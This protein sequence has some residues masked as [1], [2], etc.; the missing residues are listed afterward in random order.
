VVAVIMGV[1]CSG[2]YYVASAASEIVVHPSALTGSIGV[3]AV[4]PQLEGLAEK[5]GVDQ[6]T[7]KSGSFKD[8]GSPLRPMR[9]DERALL[10]GMID[11]FHRQFVDAV[12]AGRRERIERPALERLADGRVLT[13]A[14]AVA[15]GLADRVGYIDDAIALAMRKAGIDDAHV[16]TYVRGAV[17]DATVYTVSRAAQGPMRFSAVD[18]GGLNPV[19]RA[20]FYYVWLPETK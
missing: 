17:A 4:F 5:I 2:G 20:G 10:Q 19:S 6:V 8:I 16:V 15:H 3:V 11:S 13:G 14:E 9:D 7:I 1:G 12:F 18:F